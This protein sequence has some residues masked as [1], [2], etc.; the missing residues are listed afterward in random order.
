MLGWCFKKKK[1]EKKNPTVTLVTPK[2]GQ[3]QR[4]QYCLASTVSSL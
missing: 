4:C 3:R 1:K 2:V